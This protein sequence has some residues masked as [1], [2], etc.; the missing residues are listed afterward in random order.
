MRQAW[1]DYFDAFPQYRIFKDEVY[2]NKN[3]VF[4]VGHTQGSHIADDEESVPGSVIWKAVVRNGE[5]SEWIVYPGT[6]EIRKRFA[7]PDPV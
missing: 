7:L 1:R 3:G 4:I 6:M 2:E 5:V